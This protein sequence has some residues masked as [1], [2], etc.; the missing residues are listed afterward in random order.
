MDYY[1]IPIAILFFVAVFGANTG[2][3]FQ[4]RQAKDICTHMTRAERTAAIKR[5]ALW[6]L[7]VGMPAVIGLILGPV[8]LKSALLGVTLCALLLPLLAVV[9]WKTWFPY[10]TK[11]Q[12]SFL[13]ST[14]WAKSQGLQADD[15]QVFKWQEEK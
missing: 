11:S 2:S 5:G 6:G 3:P 13:A 1:W 9:L 12:Q 15:I 10:V 8:V 7:L 14:E 4:S